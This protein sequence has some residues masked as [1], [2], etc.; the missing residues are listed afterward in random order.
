M[1][2][3]KKKI[4]KYLETKKNDLLIAWMQRKL[5]PGKRERKMKS[6]K[7]KLVLAVALAT[8][9]INFSGCKSEKII[10]IDDGMKTNKV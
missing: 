9:T 5:K 2:E 10:V 6:M 4:L 7:L 8:F 3:K 1:R